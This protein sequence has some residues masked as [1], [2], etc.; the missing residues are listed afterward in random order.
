[1]QSTL[2]GE[3]D[4]V[5]RINTSTPISINSAVFKGHAV[6]WAAGLAS[7]PAGMFQGQKRKTSLVV[8]VNDLTAL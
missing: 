7:T 5:D 3:P 8:Q 1:M 4:R 6:L 2:H